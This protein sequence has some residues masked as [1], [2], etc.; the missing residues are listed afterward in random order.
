MASA[1]A[2]GVGSREAFGVRQLTAALFLCPNNVSVPISASEGFLRTLRQPPTGTTDNFR[3]KPQSGGCRSRGSG[4][5]VAFVP[6][7]ANCEVFELAES[8]ALAKPRGAIVLAFALRGCSHA[9]N[10]RR[11]IHPQHV[12]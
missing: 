6:A 1:D 3:A 5:Q 12:R 9:F 2:V 8:S 7:T 10:K 11:G 4:R